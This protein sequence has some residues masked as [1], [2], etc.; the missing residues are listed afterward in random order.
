[1]RCENC[2][3][4]SR[5]KYQGLFLHAL[6]LSNELI[7]YVVLSDFN[8]TWLKS[9]SD[10]SAPK[11]ARLL[12]KSKYFFCDFPFSNSI[13]I[14]RIVTTKRELTLYGI[15]DN[16]IGTVYV[17]TVVSLTQFFIHFKTVV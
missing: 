5:P 2:E 1:M 14:H 17:S 7:G 8:E 12:G 11:C 3:F 15:T 9:S 6:P 4:L 16:S 13:L 10:I